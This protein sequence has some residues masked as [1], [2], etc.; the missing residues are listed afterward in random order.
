MPY[1]SDLVDIGEFGQTNLS[2]CKDRRIPLT[3]WQRPS[4][5]ASQSFGCN[6]NENDNT[7]YFISCLHVTKN[8]KYLAIT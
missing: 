4:T 3:F 2:L 7:E 6:E 8:Y 1:I 5:F